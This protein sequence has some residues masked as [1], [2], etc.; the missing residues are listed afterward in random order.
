MKNKTETDEIIEMLLIMIVTI[1]IIIAMLIFLRLYIEKTGPQQQEPQ[2]VVIRIV[3][4][5]S[6]IEPSD[7]E[8]TISVGQG[9]DEVIIKAPESGAERRDE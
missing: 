8:L 3:T 6:F 4:E 7:D 9:E 1:L 5:E 2:E